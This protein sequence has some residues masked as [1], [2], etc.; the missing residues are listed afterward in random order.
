V[1]RAARRLFARYAQ[2]LLADQPAELGYLIKERVADVAVLIDALR[3]LT[4]RACVID[5]TI[6]ASTPRSWRGQP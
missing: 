3:R 2:R 6:V 1:A 5:S 4:E